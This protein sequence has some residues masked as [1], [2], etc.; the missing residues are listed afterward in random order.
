MGCGLY[1]NH[2]GKKRL[3]MATPSSSITTVLIA[4]VGNLFVTTIKFVAWFFS[5]SGAMLSEG[6]HSAADT[7]NQ[8]LLYLGLRRATRKSDEDFQYGYGGERFVFGLLSAAGIFFIGCGVTL[9][10]GFQSLFESHTPEVSAL[11]FIILGVSALIEGTVL[12]LAVRA[13][14][15]EAKGA[16]FFQY[17][18]ERADPAT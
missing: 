6:I 11:T 10:H 8:V 9:V 16:P 2:P 3:Y 14:K 5:G 18:R 12:L 1:Y 4:L 7:G 13:V 15:K 17:V